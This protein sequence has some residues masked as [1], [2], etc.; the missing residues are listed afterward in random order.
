MYK[1]VIIK[2]SFPSSSDL[3]RV[4]LEGYTIV[5]SASCS[6]EH[7]FIVYTLKRGG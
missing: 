2:A 4:L 6:G 5:H 3:E 1:V 7:G